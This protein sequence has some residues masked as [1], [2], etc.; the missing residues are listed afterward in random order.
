MHPKRSYRRRPQRNID[1]ARLEIAKLFT[2]AEMFYRAG[3]QEMARRRVRAAR[4][5]AMKVQLRIPEHWH[6]Y[7]RA[8]DAYLVTGENATIR[9]KDG[10]R[11]RRC[12][13]CGAV[14]RRV[15]DQPRAPQQRRHR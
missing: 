11:I 7:C 8:C 15:I 6:R 3:D 4:R 13:A 9:I 10:V 12:L 5:R 14:R 1:A 2:E